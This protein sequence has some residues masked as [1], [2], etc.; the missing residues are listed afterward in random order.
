MKNLLP[1]YFSV[2]VSF[3]FSTIIVQIFSLTHKESVDEQK[4][5]TAPGDSVRKLEIDDWLRQADKCI[6]EGRY[7]AADEYLQRVFAIQP[8][9]EIA[10]SYQDRIQFMIKQLSQRVGLSKEIQ[11]EIRKYKDLV[12][13]R[14][15]TQISSYLLSAQKLLN[16]GYFRK[17]YDHATR[18]LALDS[19]SV[20][21]KS[22]V[23]RITELLHKE[24]SE[25]SRTEAEYRYR[26]LLH[27]VWLEG[28][29][30]GEK[31]A[32]L[33]VKQKELNVPDGMRLALEREVKNQLYH[34]ALREIWLLGGISAFTPSAIDQLRENFKISRIDH[35][36]IEATLLKEVR[37]NKVK[38]T[39]FVIDEDEN[40]LMEIAH[41]L[42]LNGYAVIS[43]EN[44]EE[45]L[46]TMK[47]ITPDVVLCEVNFNSMPSGF[48]FYEFIRANA[49]TRKAPFL[50]MTTAVD[51]TTQ[52]VGKRLGV[53]DFLAKP[54]DHEILLASITG[55]MKR[56]GELQRSEEKRF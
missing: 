50:F 45:A 10:Y 11:V 27:E 46:E 55:T 15:S 42:R 5:I 1:L 6:R 41:Q 36:T 21:A 31:A 17:A 38:A 47:I 2:L 3:L 4:T 12:V 18:A 7:L 30:T 32:L 43:A 25:I 34:D 22:L 48:D 53:D 8:E 49:S 26:S 44:I 23:Q 19:D 13:Q 24:S 51:R 40:N 39:V 9:N 35:S 14:K 16:E 20:Y 28:A 29:P 54:V 37:K 52:I 56:R 33:D